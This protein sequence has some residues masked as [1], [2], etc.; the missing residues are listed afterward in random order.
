M[1]TGYFAWGTYQQSQSRYVK[2]TVSEP[3]KQQGKRLVLWSESGKNL[4]RSELLPEPVERNNRSASE[5]TLDAQCL[6][7]GPFGSASKADDMQQRLFSLGVAS[8]ERSDNEASE[9]DHW[10]HIPPL[11]SREAAI[12]L[13]RELQGQNIDSFVITQGEL[14]N[15]ISLGL[16]SKEVSANKVSS[17]LLQAGY[18]TR[19][20][21]LARQPQTYWLELAVKEADKITE[22]MWE[23]F[24]DE[25]NGLKVLEKN[26][27]GIASESSIH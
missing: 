9:Y 5:K 6:V 15:G 14:A 11:A 18:E 8:R 24:A 7:V 1:N 27:K 4:P 17:R 10:V 26:C 25:Y 21:Q 2:P 16:F 20:K 12:R 23:R 19:I 22:G 13:L 3:E